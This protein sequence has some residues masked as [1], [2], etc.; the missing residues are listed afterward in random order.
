MNFEIVPVT[1]DMLD[2][3]EEMEKEC[4]SVPW[5]REMLQYQMRGNNVFIAAVSEGEVMGYIGMMFVLDEGYISNVAVTGKYRRMGIAKA[6]I[7]ALEAKCREM[8]LSFMT[9][10][11]RESNTPAIS[12]YAGLGFEEVGVR[13]NYYDKPREN[14]ILMTRNLD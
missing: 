6:L 14:A 1:E 7:R 11:V 13:K 5:N 9:L 2:T 10:E 4:F 12:L 3:L 8:Q